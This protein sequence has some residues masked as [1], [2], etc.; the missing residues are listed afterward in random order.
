MLKPSDA[1]YKAS[2]IEDENYVFRMFLKGHADAD[3]LDKQFK[4]LHD[5][6]FTQYDCSKCRNCCKMFHGTIPK[7]DISKD[8]LHLGLSETEF[9]ERYLTEQAEEESYQTN[10][11]PCDFWDEYG[12]CSLGDCKPKDC[13][14]FPYSSANGGQLSCYSARVS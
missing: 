11:R 6:L 10:N 3:T 7:D 13:K 14:E 5:E 1:A 8:A 2:K 9:V 12:S 4:A